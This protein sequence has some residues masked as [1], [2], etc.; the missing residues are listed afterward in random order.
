MVGEGGMLAM[1]NRYA[2]LSTERLQQSHG[3]HSP[4]RAKGGGDNQEALDTGYWD[5]E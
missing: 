1:T 2:S 5:I 4:L 3:L